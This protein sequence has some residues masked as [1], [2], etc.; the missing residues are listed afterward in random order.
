MT[1]K[2]S[3]ILLVGGVGIA[4]GLL[5]LFSAPFGDERRRYSMTME[6]MTTEGLR[7]GASVIEA[8]KKKQLPLMGAPGINYDVEGEAIAVDL[9]AGRAVF[10]LLMGE[11]TQFEL[12]WFGAVRGRVTPPLPRAYRREEQAALWSELLRTEA[13]V[14]LNIE[15]YPR[16][17]T[18]AD[19]S[20]PKSVEAVSPGRLDQVFGPGYRLERITLR[21]TDA[22]LTTA[23]RRRLPWLRPDRQRDTG[24]GG[25]ATPRPSLPYA[26]SQLEFVR[27]R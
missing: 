19:D 8:R 24:N 15:D 21:P 3:T 27:S 22:P 5:A 23:I 11:A 10:A 18:F 17:V 2:L 4:T 16:L 12:A 9:G 26:F 20:D 7:T 6:V 1:R 13:V 14:T 25:Q